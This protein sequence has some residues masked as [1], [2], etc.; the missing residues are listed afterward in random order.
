M[1]DMTT[2][3]KCDGR[4][5][6]AAFRNV[7]G[8]LCFTCKG[9]GQVKAR[10]TAPARSWACIYAGRVLFHKKARTEAEAHRKALAHLRAHRDAPAFESV[11]EASVLVKPSEQV[12]G[13]N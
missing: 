1:S 7:A 11:T 8:G 9:R 13:V 2:C 5:E 3:P 10:K 6:I 12:Q 4:G